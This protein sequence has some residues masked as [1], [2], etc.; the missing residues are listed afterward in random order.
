MIHVLKA[1]QKKPTEET[2]K[3]LVPKKYHE[4]LKVF[5]KNESEHMLL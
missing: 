3:E 1:Q 2:S 4:F 5:L